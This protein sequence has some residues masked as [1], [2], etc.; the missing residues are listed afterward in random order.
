MA[1]YKN[2]TSKVVIRKVMRDLKLST[3]NWIDDAIEWMGEALEHIGASPQ[4]EKKVCTLTVAEYTTC[5]PS[6]LYYINLVGINGAMTTTVNSELQLITSQIADIKALLDAD[7]TQEVNS[8][9][10]KLNSR[11][12]VLEG[13]Y[14]KNPDQLTPLA[15]ATSE[16]P[17]ALH[18]DKCINVNAKTK[19]TYFINNGKIKTSFQTGAICLS[20]MAFPLDDECYPMIPDDIS[21]KE[22]MF[23]YIYKK[24]LLGDP[25][26]KPNG[27]DYAMAEGQWKYYCTQARNNANYPDIDR[28]ESFLNQW[29]RLIPSMSQHDSNFEQLNTREQLSRSLES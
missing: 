19:E 11:L 16:F 4:L 22:A 20:Y 7:P 27:I 15:Y 21:F 28:M 13:M 5:L 9:L 3:D 29:V 17:T 8:E 25:N 18:C 6:D 23:W 10:F 24:L 12:A 1:I 26:A 2:I 14:W